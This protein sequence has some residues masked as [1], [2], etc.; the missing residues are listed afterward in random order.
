MAGRVRLVPEQAARI[1]RLGPDA[2]CLQEVTVRA[3]PLWK[4]ALRR[5]GL[6]CVSHPAVRAPDESR[7][8]RLSV[9]TATRTRVGAEPVEGVPWPERA[10]TVRLTDGLELVNVHSP[11]SSTPGLVKV[12]TH[13]A[14]HAYLSRRSDSACVLCGD[15]NTPRREHPDGQVW[16]FARDRYGRLR[17]ERGERWDQAELALI[18]GLEPYGF[19]DA[20]RTLHGYSEREPSWE[21]PKWGGGWRLDHLIVSAHV[22]VRSCHYEH[23][24]RRAG[25]SDHSALVA[26]LA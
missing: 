21:W 3:A 11:I 1:A 9:L 25:L 14:V 5:I 19:R 7:T 16:T 2:V 8:R 18:R 24:W 6:E 12:R 22:E 13:E 4:H 20:F 23:D 26:E 17:S 15:L 10:L